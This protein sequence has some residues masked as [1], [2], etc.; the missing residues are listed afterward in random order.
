MLSLTIPRSSFGYFLFAIKITNNA[1]IFY[2]FAV[3]KFMIHLTESERPGFLV[4]SL[5]EPR[6]AGLSGKQWLTCYNSFPEY[7]CLVVKKLVC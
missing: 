2:F 1:V 3:K 5:K 4:R 6:L 7:C